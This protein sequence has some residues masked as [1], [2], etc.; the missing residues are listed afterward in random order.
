MDDPQRDV[1]SQAVLFLGLTGILSLPF[2]VVLF[3]RRDLV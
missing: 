3:A 2:W 1:R